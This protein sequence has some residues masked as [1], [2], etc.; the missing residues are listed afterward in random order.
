MPKLIKELKKEHTEILGMLYTIKSVGVE[1]GGH[2]VL[3][4]KD[5]LLN[6]LAKE[7]K[8]LYPVLKEKAKD[9]KKLQ[10]TLDIYAKDMSKI[11]KFAIE[12]F[13]KY[14]NAPAKE[15]FHESVTKMLEVLNSRIQREE[16]FL[17]TEYNKL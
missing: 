2:L 11:S 14:E 6:H 7:D 17:Y 15:G 16:K 3:L 12:F 4:A 1:D 5:A 10:E 8:E 9:N 13:E